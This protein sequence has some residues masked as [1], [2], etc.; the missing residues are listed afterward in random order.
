[1]VAKPPMTARDTSWNLLQDNMP[2]YNSS[3]RISDESNVLWV[4]VRIPLREDGCA[5]HAAAKGDRITT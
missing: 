5:A 3:I 1:M 2:V 4:Q